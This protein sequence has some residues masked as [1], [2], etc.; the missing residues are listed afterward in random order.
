MRIAKTMKKLSF[1]TP[2]LALTSAVFFSAHAMELRH[3]DSATNVNRDARLALLNS[4]PDN[5]L[6]EAASGLCNA[7]LQKTYQGRTFFHLPRYEKYLN[8]HSNLPWQALF[9]ANKKMID[10]IE[11]QQKTIYAKGVALIEALP[12]KFIHLQRA[13]IYCET[14]R[15]LLKRQHE[16]N[17]AQA[18]IKAIQKM[19]LDEYKKAYQSERVKGKIAR[20][21]ALHRWNMCP[22]NKYYTSPFDRQ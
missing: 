18:S 19:A 15:E 9:L 2:I 11:N 17:S 10:A 20:H 16:N 13:M 14:A 7:S 8:A 22:C 3:Q 12:L 1:Y 21:L 5:Q 6:E 4:V